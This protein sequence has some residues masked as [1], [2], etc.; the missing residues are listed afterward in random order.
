[1]KTPS[2]TPQDTALVASAREARRRRL[3]WIITG[4]VLLV[5]LGFYSVKAANQRSAFIRWRPQVL[6]LMQGQN[7]YD[8]MSLFPNPP[9]LPLTLY[10]LMSLPPLVGAML[11][12]FLKASLAL[13][14]FR[15][16]LQMARERGIA[17]PAWVEAVILLMVSRPIL[18]DLHHGN[19]NILIMFL[20]VASLYL[21]TRARDGMAGAVMALAITYKVTPGLFLPYFIYKRAWKT[22]AALLASMVVYLLVL[23]SVFLGPRF[24][25]LCLSTWYRNMIMPYVE[26]GEVGVQEI[27]QSM[28]GVLTRLLTK[29]EGT[30]ERY[31]PLLELNLLDL[32]PG[33]VSILVKGLSIVLVLV[34][35]WFCRLD[36]K[37][38][39][40]PRFLGEFS[41]VVLTMLFVSERSWKHHYVTLLLPLTYLGI[42]L[43]AGRWTTPKERRY[44]IGGLILAMLMIASTSSELG[45][46]LY[47]DMGHKYAQG[48]GMFLWAGVLIYGL[49]AWRLFVERSRPGIE[50][51]T[52]VAAI[53][54]SPS[55]ESEDESPAMIASRRL[56][57]PSSSRP[58]GQ[59]GPERRASALDTET[60][61]TL[62][63]SRP[64]TSAES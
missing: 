20:V 25:W 62:Q 31:D 63:E 35:A 37:R 46:W 36:P 4:I 41:L 32:D 51:V 15:L 40:D 5:A 3:I 2:R 22:V 18:S 56:D 27:N 38:R 55:E 11:W 1:M 53:S 58:T 54:E 7:I 61:G 24:N 64:P 33:L 47:Q 13:I 16:C 21:W 45:G 12:F 34:G 28:V 23:P 30:G 39:G 9:L 44:L 26:D 6:E 59:I 10:P 43:Q 14:A 50:P 57:R 8:E 52:A 29:A 42:R 49:T 19:N 17:V 48:Y 60:G